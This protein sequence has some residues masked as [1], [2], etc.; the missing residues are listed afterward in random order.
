MYNYICYSTKDHLM[1]YVEFRLVVCPV[2]LGFDCNN[3][4]KFCGEEVYHLFMETLLLDLP[5]RLALDFILVS[6]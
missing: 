3:F 6:S 1:V 2:K 4:S 5:G